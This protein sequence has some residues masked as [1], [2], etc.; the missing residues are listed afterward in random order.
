MSALIDDLKN[1]YLSKEESFMYDR[2]GCFKMEETCNA[3]RIEYTEK[4]I[5]NTASR[6]CDVI[7]ISRSE[8]VLALSTQY[9]MPNEFYLDIP[10][11]K[12]SKIGCVTMRVNA[13]NTMKVR[14][15]RL[16]TQKELDRI[17]VFS[18]HPMHRNMTLDV[19]AW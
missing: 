19:R 10:D 7:Q 6:R 18:T 16:L 4:V 15:L 1:T 14:F 11:A 13:N 9:V 5:L 17:F 2:E 12:I 3:A 8:A